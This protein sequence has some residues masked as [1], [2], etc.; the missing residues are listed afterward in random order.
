MFYLKNIFLSVLFLGLCFSPQLHSSVADFFVEGFY[1]LQQGH[2]FYAGPQAYYVVRNRDGGTRQSGWVGGGRI[3]YE[4][5]KGNSLYWCFEA[6][7]ASGDLKGRSGFNNPLKST[8][9]DTTYE[10]R[11]G[12]T[13]HKCACQHFFFS[14]YILFEYIHERNDFKEPST[15]LA[16]TTIHSNLVGAGFLSQINPYPFLTV[17]INFSVKYMLSGKSNFKNFPDAVDPDTLI[18]FSI[19]IGS[20]THYRLE[21]PVSYRPF[22]Y[23]RDKISLGLVPFYEFRQ[24]GSLENHPINFSGTTY[25]FYGLFFR[26]MCCI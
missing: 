14:P 3:G 5:L 10:G 20:R 23:F 22:D 13:F 21:I 16:D 17:G 19:G 7:T 15:L 6:A 25:S 26:F 8:F 2:R 12:Y 1:N 11:L 4:R 9:Q 18:K 24:Y